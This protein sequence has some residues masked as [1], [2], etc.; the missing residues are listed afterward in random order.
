MCQQRSRSAGCRQHV[1]AGLTHPWLTGKYHLIAWH[2]PPAGFATQ[3][4]MKCSRSLLPA[5]LGC[6]GS[7]HPL[8][9]SG[10]H[11]LVS[12]FAVLFATG[13]GGGSTADGAGRLHCGAEGHRGHPPPREHRAH[14]GSVAGELVVVARLSAPQTASQWPV[15]PTYHWCLRG[16]FDA[17]RDILIL[18]LPLPLSPPAPKRA[19]QLTLSK[20][21]ISCPH[22]L[23]SLK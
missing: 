18:A 14:L 11:H 21:C 2:T 10:L 6:T 16:D 5:A 8:P 22:V 20:G 7:Q 23:H 19:G 9:T 1:A 12:L 15:M 13:L 4:S 17:L 3:S